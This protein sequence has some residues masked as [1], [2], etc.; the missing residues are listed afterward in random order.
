M[1]CAASAKYGLCAASTTGLSG[2][3]RLRGGACHRL[4]RSSPGIEPYQSKKSHLCDRTFYF[5]GSE[6]PG[7]KLDPEELFADLELLYNRMVAL[8]VTMRDGEV[9]LEDLDGKL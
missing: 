4:A 9:Y 2:V 6:V 3:D 7:L 1:P 8:G 5:G